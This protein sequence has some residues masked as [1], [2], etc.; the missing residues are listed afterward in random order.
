M[1]RETINLSPRFEDQESKGRISQLVVVMREA[2]KNMDEAE[3]AFDDAKAI[4]RRLERED[5]PTLMQELGYKSIVLADGS[6]IDIVDDV[7]TSISEARRTAAHE[8]LTEHGFSGIIKSAISMEF[9]RKELDEARR[10]AEEI[11]ELAD[12]RPVSIQEK[13][14]PMTLKAFVKEQLE[15]GVAIPFDLFSIFPFSRA[16]IK[17]AK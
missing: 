6:V 12:G 8:W 2:K 10:I 14:H 5:L 3:K 1:V 16:K 7:E 13:I 4:Y 11:S 9:D 17:S 15:K